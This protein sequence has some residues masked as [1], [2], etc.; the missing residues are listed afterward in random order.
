MIEKM[1]SSGHSQRERTLGIIL[2]LT[3]KR[4][5]TT[6]NAKAVSRHVASLNVDISKPIELVFYN[7]AE[8]LED[9]VRVNSEEELYAA[10]KKGPLSDDIR[11]SEY[12]IDLTQ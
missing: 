3:D 7:A 9:R 6:E 10:L 8:K 1:R 12:K 2:S 4:N 5:K 11:K